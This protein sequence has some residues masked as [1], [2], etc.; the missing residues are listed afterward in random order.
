MIRSADAP[1]TD[2]N[3][4]RGSLVW[5]R[6]YWPQA[7]IVVV[8]L[9]VE[10]GY[11]TL[12]PLALRVLIDDAVTE[13]DAPLVVRTLAIMAAGYV[14][15]AAASTIRAWTTSSTGGRLLT[16]A[17]VRLF[18]HVQRLSADSATR[19]SGGDVGA[20]FVTD[21]NAVEVALTFALPEIAW[22]TLALALNLPLLFALDVPLAVVA[23]LVIPLAMIGPRV[24]APRV[25]VVGYARRQ[26]EGHLLVTLQ[27]Q[28][29]GRGVIRAFGLEPL[30]RARV[31]H[32]LE[33]LGKT[34]SREAFQT[35]LVGRATTFGS[36][37]GQLLVF[38]T[39]SVLVFRGELSVGTFVGFIG[40]LL[41]VGEGVRWLGF[42][43]PPFLQAAGPM[44]RVD[45]L[46]AE[47]LEPADAPDAIAP[48]ELHGDLRVEHVFFDYAGH[49][50]PVLRDVTLRIAQGQHVAIV[51]ASGS[52]KTTALGL[53]MRAR[54][55][56]SGSVALGGYDLRALRRES[57][58]RRLGVVFQESFLFSGTVRENIRLGRSDA[59]DDD[60]ERAAELAQL[61][62]SVQRL[63]DGYETEVGERG[64]ALSGGQR[65]RVALARAMLRDPAVLLL[66]E[67]TSAL[68]P[69]T[70]ADFIATLR[71][72]RRRPHPNPLP[73][74]EGVSVKGEGVTVVM[75]THRLQTIVDADAIF[76]LE[77]GRLVQQGTHVELL[78]QAD[79]P[80]AHMWASQSGF[81]VSHD[82]FHAEVSAER[83]RL[84]PLFA[85]LSDATLARLAHDFAAEH[86][87]PDRVLVRQ[88]DPGDRFY[89]I[90]RGTVE[91]VRVDADGTERVLNVLYDGDYFGELALLEHGVRT[92]SVR[93]RTACVVLSLGS[94]QFERLLTDESTIR[95]SI[96]RTVV[97]RTSVL[98]RVSPG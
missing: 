95:E 76:V 20:R 21:L 59:S 71:G 80:Y 74:G 11:W 60:V 43:L 45:E 54:D 33:S 39:G 37:L 85:E 4:V 7:A 73:Q 13:R 66:D 25:A 64:G 15:M 29:G 65:Q 58:L 81:S 5:L 86:V 6:P 97:E 96:Q 24:L 70:E 62:Q 91:V 63:P 44:Q 22:G 57:L 84:I 31:R 82:G 26:A 48:P 75:V 89:L 38:A 53:L 46:L 77:Q 67:P 10:V 12:V 14:A 94:Q 19:V 68:D 61:H 50:Q 88:G 55:P 36:A 79:G 1:G 83:L 49:T 42:G 56:S 40:L 90:A 16:D 28:I 9:A 98:G 47:S 27:E 32:E 2:V 35:R 23:C 3:L 52:G 51:G 8:A 34:S 41:N 78:E 30:M 18:D 92:A 87:P 72:L 69:A 17:R 93:S